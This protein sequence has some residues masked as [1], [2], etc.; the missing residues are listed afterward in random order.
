MI[1]LAGYHSNNE[2]AYLDSLPKEAK[3]K[4][5]PGGMDVLGSHVHNV[6][7]D[8]LGTAQ[9]QLRVLQLLVDGQLCALVQRAFVDCVRHTEVDQFTSGQEV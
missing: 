6:A 3:D 4:V 5:L 2:E 1:I 7:A 9:G 8:G